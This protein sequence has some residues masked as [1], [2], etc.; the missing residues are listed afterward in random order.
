MD[1]VRCHCWFSGD[2]NSLGGIPVVTYVLMLALAVSGQQEKRPKP[3]HQPVRL[4]DGRRA[5]LSCPDDTR[6]DC[7]LSVSKPKPSGHAVSTHTK[8]G[9]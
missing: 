8:A 9:K 6:Q 7:T 4:I 2:S 1:M 3:T 5:Y